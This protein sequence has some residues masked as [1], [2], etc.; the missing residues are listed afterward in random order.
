M[1]AEKQLLEELRI[2][3][4]KGERRV[5]A[6]ARWILLGFSV[7]LVGLAAFLWQRGSKAAT[8]RTAAVREAGGGAAR[9]ILNASGYVTARRR[10][11]VSAKITGKVKE[12]LVE[13]GLSVTEGQ[14]VGRL[15]DATQSVN[16]ALAEAQLVQA[17]RA[18]EESEVRLRE[19]NIILRRTKALVAE[20]VQSQS[21]LDTAQAD[22]DALVAKLNELREEV[23]VAE[24]L[25]AVRKQDTDDTIIR[26]PFSGV[27]ISKDA[28]PG[29]MISPI[30][31]GGGFTRTGICTL[32]DMTSLEI[33]VDVNESYIARVEPRQRVD[34]TLDAYP[35][36]HIPAYVFTTIPS[37][38][39]QKA[40]MKVRIK[41]DKLDPKILPDMGV[42][43]TFLET[44]TAGQ[45]A[46]RSRVLVPKTAVRREDSRDVVYV[47]LG[48]RVER[49]A[50]TLG[51]IEGE[52]VV[53]VAG[54]TAGEQVVIEGPADLAQ[55]QKVKV[56]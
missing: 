51:P 9:G 30:S 16:L 32:V 28:Q 50:V 8:V 52:D 15:D 40:T 41:F 23:A 31:A 12:V 45:A 19:A 39:R 13:E 24:R 36:W 38:D 43:V 7:L 53:V 2:D 29:E 44:P 37:A 25:V 49:R 6:S 14:I 22:S 21:V 5:P 34:A 17:R 1:T 3:R 4:S 46:P 56:E 18:L 33:E 47:V 55:A 42:K 54:L 10:A 20:G 26:A 48:D 11:T 27:V 35:D